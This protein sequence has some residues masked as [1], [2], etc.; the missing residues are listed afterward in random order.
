MAAEQLQQL[1]VFGNRANL[2]RI[3]TRGAQDF[4]PE[5]RTR[6]AVETA[7]GMD[8]G[9]KG[10]GGEPLLFTSRTHQYQRLAAAQFPE[11]FQQEAAFGFGERLSDGKLLAGYRLKVVQNQ[12]EALRSQPLCH[13]FLR[14]LLVWREPETELARDLEE[15]LLPRPGLVVVFEVEHA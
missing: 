13:G 9:V 8:V 1:A 3:R 14:K 15:D 5:R 10:P 7:Q 11:E 2:R 4:V 6:L 12:Q